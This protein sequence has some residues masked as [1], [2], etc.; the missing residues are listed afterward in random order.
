[1]LTTYLLIGGL[2]AG[3]QRFHHAL[4]WRRYCAA[5]GFYAILQVAMIFGF[6]NENQLP[7]AALAIALLCLILVCRG[8]YLARAALVPWKDN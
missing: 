5:L 8:A 3:I 7:V 1:M 2:I 4:F 6:L